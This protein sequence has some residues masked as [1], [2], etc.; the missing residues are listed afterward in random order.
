MISTLQELSVLYEIASL[1]FETTENEIFDLVTD[2][3]IR[4]FSTR[5]CAIIKVKDGRPVKSVDFGFKKGTNVYDIV[6]EQS[7]NAFKYNLVNGILFAE[8]KEPFTVKQKKYLTILADR[9]NEILSLIGTKKLKQ[10]AKNIQTLFKTIPDPIIIVDS[11]NKILEVNEKLLEINPVPKTKII[12]K[13]LHKFKNFTEESK[14]ELE[15][16]LYTD[17]KN[18]C[19]IYSKENG[20]EKCYEVN[21]TKVKFEGKNAYLLIFRDITK[22]KEID[23]IKSEFISLTSHQLRTPASGIKWLC[24]LLIKERVGKLKKEQNELI[25]DINEFNN[26]MI[27][28]VD[29]LLKVAVIRSKK[30]NIL[31]E[32]FSIQ[33]LINEV[34]GDHAHLVKEGKIEIKTNKKSKNISIFADKEKVRQIFD[35]LIDNSIKYCEKKPIITIDWK[36][37]NNDKIQVE[38]SD[39]GVGIPQEEQENIFNAFFRAKNALKFDVTRAGLGL[40]VVKTIIDAM[41]CKIWLKSNNGKGTTFYFTLPKASKTV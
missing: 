32:K 19:E 37:F 22:R 25:K 23:K 21:S 2:K 26:R 41:N 7:K 35:N 15:A 14:K 16:K 38:V 33:S 20:N 18:P 11:K 28:L 36:L 5:R 6:K 17:T 29:E 3:L 12:S 30:N 8:K 4:V 27:R 40:Y 13:I 31:K 10:E 39:N 9:L 34:V 1:P 24:E